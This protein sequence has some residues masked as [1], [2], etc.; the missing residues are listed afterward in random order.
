MEVRR[1]WGVGQSVPAISAA[2]TETHPTRTGDGQM[3]VCTAPH[4]GPVG[5][6]MVA[7]ASRS[8]THACEQYKTSGDNPV[9]A[10]GAMEPLPLVLGML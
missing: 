1:K 8:S 7:F 3:N 4:T 5:S 6:P 9:T 10:T 2:C